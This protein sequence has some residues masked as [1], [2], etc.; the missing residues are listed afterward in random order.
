MI[1]HI[2]TLEKHN[3][4]ITINCGHPTQ[5]GITEEWWQTVGGSVVQVDGRSATRRESRGV[6][7]GT[8]RERGNVDM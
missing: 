7:S 3:T 1:G 4:S 6:E 8:K 2:D 5:K